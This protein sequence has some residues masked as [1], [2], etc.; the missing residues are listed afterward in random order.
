MTGNTTALS[1][2]YFIRQYNLLLPAFILAHM[3]ALRWVRCVNGGSTGSGKQCLSDKIMRLC[4]GY[5]DSVLYPY[6]NIFICLLLCC[7]PTEFT[8]ILTRY[9]RNLKVS[10]TG[11]DILS[12]Q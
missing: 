11:S 12:I 1:G 10:E 9:L 4:S 2:A 7:T 8:L 6:F 5:E 3:C